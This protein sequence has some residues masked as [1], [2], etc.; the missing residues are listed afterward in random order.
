MVVLLETVVSIVIVAD[1]AITVGK[2]PLSDQ[3]KYKLVTS[4]F[5]A[6]G[7]DG[8]IGRLKLPEGAV[9]LFDAIIRDALADV[10]RKQKG[11]IDPTKLLS[12]STRRL[13][14]EGSRPV[15]C[16]G[17]PDKPGHQPS[18]ESAE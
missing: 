10:L 8:L 1:V 2:K 15:S 9:Q 14:F 17:K 5:L 11:T 4:D 6:S 12:P 13:E 7:G 18:Q 16:G 3:A